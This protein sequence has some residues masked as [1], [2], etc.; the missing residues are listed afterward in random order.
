MHPPDSILE[1][2]LYARDLGAVEWFY[3]DVLGLTVNSAV[4]D[5]FVFFVCGRQM[6]LVF[7]PDH[8]RKNDPRIGIPRH[9]TEGQGHVCFRARSKAELVAWRDHFRAKG[10]A[11]EHEHSWKNGALSIYVRDPAGNSVE[12][13]E[14]AIWELD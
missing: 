11:V 5:R 8:S 10:I 2:V 7:N 13:G 1:T 6:L 4:P 14:A 9:G 3:T 12:I